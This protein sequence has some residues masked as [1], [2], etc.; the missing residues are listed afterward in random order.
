M[1]IRI[2]LLAEA[3]I[4]ED[5]RRRDPAKRAIFA[6]ALLVALALVWSSSLLLKE[7]LAKKD[8]NQ[9]Q[10]EIQTRTNEYNRILLS[11]KKIADSQNKL[12]DV[13]ELSAARFLQGSLL[14][15]LQQATV[16][17]VQLTRLRVDQSY[18]YTEGTKSQTNRFGVVAGRPPTITEKVVVTLDARDSSANPGDQVN[19]FNDAVAQQSYFQTMLD[20]TNGVR[21]AGLSA[22]QTGP[23]GKPYVSFT[24]ECRYPAQSR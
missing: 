19:K 7:M 9:V 21:L 16:P 18:F 6:G 14:N 22:P 8:M 5:L 10:S 3:L 13:K 12:D 15:A 2:N 17:G 1:P 24:L 4:A 11:T 20:K 23:D